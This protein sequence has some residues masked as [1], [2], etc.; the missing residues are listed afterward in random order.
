MVLREKEGGRTGMCRFLPTP[1][2][3]EPER[4]RAFEG[5][6]WGRGESSSTRERFI[7]AEVVGCWWTREVS[8][9]EMA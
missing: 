7:G 6:L 9:V 4:W 3:S 5:V 2:A 8:G 1:T